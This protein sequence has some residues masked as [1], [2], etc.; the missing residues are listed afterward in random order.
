M[1]D[2]DV[3]VV[4]AGLAGNTAAYLLAKAG[5]EVLVIERSETIGGKNV[6]GGR[7]YS[8]SLERFFPDFAKEAPLGRRITKERISMLT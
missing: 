4:G 8:H 1:S 3:I 6:T 2:Y 7:M 5:L